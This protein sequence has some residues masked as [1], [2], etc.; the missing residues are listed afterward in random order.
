MQGWHARGVL[1]RWDMRLAERRSV[2]MFMIY[3]HVWGAIYAT[4]VAWHCISRRLGFAYDIVDVATMG[5]EK[6]L[7]I[8]VAALWLAYYYE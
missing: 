6:R 5:L 8:P 3:G 7:S 1:G 2:F 4:G